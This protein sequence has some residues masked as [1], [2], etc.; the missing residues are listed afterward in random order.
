MRNAKRIK[1]EKIFSLSPTSYMYNILCIFVAWKIKWYFTANDLLP[2]TLYLIF[3][4]QI[5]FD[6]D[7]DLLPCTTLRY[8]GCGCQGS[9]CIS[10]Q[11]YHQPGKKQI[12]PLLFIFFIF[13]PEYILVFWP[14]SWTN[15]QYLKGSVC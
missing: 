2:C 10:G 6:V 9:S 1:N 7:C 8:R 4:G 13:S 11:Q 3:I 15:W 14:Q 5:C 12:I